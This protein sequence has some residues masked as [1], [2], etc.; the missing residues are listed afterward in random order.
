MRSKFKWIFTLLV[1]FTMQFSFAQQKTVTGTVTS[2]GAKLPGATVSIAGTQQGTQTDENGKFSIK[3]SEGD[4]LEVSFLGKDPKTVTV[5]AGNVVNVVLATSTQTLEVIQVVGAMG[6][7]RKP[8]AVTNQQ[9]TVTNKELT[10]AAQPNAIIALTGKVSG[11]QINTTSNGV[12]AGTRIVLR[13][14]RTITGNNQALVVIDNAI[15][16]AAILGQI[17]PS[18]IENMNVLKGAQGGALYGAQGVNGVIIVTTKKGSKSDK[19]S[20]SINSS[21]DFETVSFV[22]DRQTKY[23]QGWIYDPTFNASG[24][25]PWENGAWGPAFDD[26]AYAGQLVETGLPQADGNFQMLEWKGDKDNIKKFFR[27][28]TI[29]QNGISINAGGADSYAGVSFSRQNTSFM[30]Q[31]DELR[32]NNFNIKFGKKLGKFRADGNVSY[33]NQRTSTTSSELYDDLMQVASNIPVERFNNAQI[34]HGWSVYIDNP[35]WT[36]KNNRNDSK[37]DFVNGNIALG[38]ELNKNINVTYN[39]NIQLRSTEAQSHVNGFEDYYYDIMGGSYVD[40]G[41]HG[42]TSNYYAN[43]SRQRNFYGD[44]MFNFDYELTNDIGMKV[45]VGNNIQDSYF[46]VI[47]QGGTNLDVEGWYHINNVLNPDPAYSLANTETRTR[48]FALFSNFDFNYKDYLFLNVTAREERRST[49]AKWF[50]YPSV[51][52]SFIPT[53]AFDALKDNKVLNFAKLSANYTKVGNASAVAAYATDEIGVFPTGF[54]FGTLSSYISNQRQVNKNINPEIATTF[55]VS[56]ALGFFNDRITLDGS[57]YRTN[58]KNLITFATT[59]SAT[60]MSAFQDN[61]GRLHTDGF[62]IDLGLT[63]IKTESFKWNI[64]ASYSTYKTI[65]DKV[66]D[67]SK[68]VTL[69][70][71]ANVAIVAE[72]G[73]EFP[74]IKGTAYER[75]PNGNIVVNPATGTPLKTGLVNIGKSTPDYILGLTNSFEYKGLRLAVVADYRT[76]H[77]FY[78][79][80]KSTLGFAGHLVESADFDR[81]ESFVIPGS[82]YESAP[83]VYTANTT[84]VGTGN[85]S[86]GGALGLYPGV[87]DYY[88]G[89]S[90]RSGE[91]FLID[92]TSLQIRELSL[93]YTLPKKMLKNSGINS[94]TFGVNARNPFI[95]LADGKFLKAKNGGENQHFADPEASI[96]STSNAQ[97]FANAG[98]YPS[99]RTIGGSINITF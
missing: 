3:A 73:E 32:R 44:L 88:G 64:K 28:G 7:K 16:S 97:G 91:A 45:N 1:A 36:I 82:V 74:L 20:V 47:T 6:I 25:V 93:S 56:A 58:T 78:S 63:P 35:Y 65:I 49:I 83:G 30:V 17:A 23:G 59:S 96:S 5:G 24:H 84:P 43:Q 99:S 4:V 19:L 26:P 61:T 13:G 75:D 10:Q 51:G 89:T 46:K 60:G 27:T 81:Y 38:Y 80:T 34:Q 54:P 69:L 95:F 40:Y 57:L 90:Y 37:S 11:L 62:E 22:P 66:T 87:V 98:Q 85:G 68:S 50:F 14:A 42:I 21:V 48:D 70:S 12:P 31:D 94:F 92:A 41:G 18:E 72:E 8:D 15:S 53:K 29:F 55:E 71:N 77:S 33:I 67:D 2:D 76:G 39:G 86:N 52:M 79:E 9:Q